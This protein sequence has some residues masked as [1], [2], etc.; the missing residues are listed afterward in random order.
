MG[1]IQCSIVFAG[2]T[3]LFASGSARA[4]CLLP[5]ENPG[6]CVQ[7]ASV[8]GSSIQAAVDFV[9]SCCPASRDAVVYVSDGIFFEH[10]S[11]R[12][13]IT[14]AGLGN[15]TTVI[16]GD[17][18]G[19]VVDIPDT[20]ASG[21]VTLA[22]LELRGGTECIRASR[23]ALLENVLISQ[24]TQGGIGIHVLAGEVSFPE[25]SITVAADPGSTG[26]L[27]APVVAGR[28][29]RVILGTNLPGS[30]YRPPLIIQVPSGVGV[31]VLQG[32][33]ADLTGCEIRGAGMGVVVEGQVTM[34]SCLISDSSVVGLRIESNPEAMLGASFCTIAKN[35][36]GIR[37]LST[38][39]ASLSF[40]YGI[41]WANSLGDYTDRTACDQFFHSD[42]GV[43]ECSAGANPNQNL[44]VDPE[45]MDATNSDIPLRDYHLTPASPLLDLSEG[46]F[47]SDFTGDPCKDLDG[48]PR[49]KN[50]TASAPI[51]DLGAYEASGPPN[52]GTSAGDV[53]GVVFTDATT[54]D[55]Y[56]N[57]P[58]LSFSVLRGTGGPAGVPLGYVLPALVP[59]AQNL[60][61]GP[62]S[63]L[64]SPPPGSFFYY[65]VYG[66]DS[67]Q[68]PGTLGFAS[69]AERSSGPIPP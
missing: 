47:P 15:P 23:N 65:V 6:N 50:A 44:E 37:N 43:A 39:P 20:G 52:P 10:V 48:T 46:I 36:I 49:L 32:G 55:W 13:S 11:L 8:A 28:P 26:V 69:C 14:L 17:S 57:N 33:S 18:T 61:G 25:G 67:L 31:R 58:D 29:T 35:E 63:D 2:L 41:V 68:R 7:Q 56:N 64:A 16:E 24:T 62:V 40:K 34:R 53:T 38:V 42:L 21:I 51:S 30:P 60:P 19:P 66:I 59:I 1:R 3:I 12:R 4:Q 22:G 27:V 54:L 9:T 45:F 5:P